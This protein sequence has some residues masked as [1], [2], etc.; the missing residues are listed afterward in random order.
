MPGRLARPRLT[1]GIV[2]LT[3]MSAPCPLAE[4]RRWPDRGC[5]HHRQPVI[6]ELARRDGRRGDRDGPSKPQL[7]ERCVQTLRSSIATQTTGPNRRRRP[8]PRRLRW[9]RERGQAAAKC[10]TCLA[11]G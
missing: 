9:R 7:V 2:L 6:S 8:E 10:A 3:P 11:Q 1:S 4:D 5:H